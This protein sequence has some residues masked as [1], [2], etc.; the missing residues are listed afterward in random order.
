MGILIG[1]CKTKTTQED[2]CVSTH[3]LTF[4]DIFRHNQA[5]FPGIIQAYPGTIQAYSG[6]VRTLCN[7]AIF[8]SLTYSEPEGYS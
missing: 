6:I 7:P 2:L 1:T 3:I 8:R 4:S 5:Y